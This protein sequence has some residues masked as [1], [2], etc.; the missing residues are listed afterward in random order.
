MTTTNNARDNGSSPEDAR[1]FR[2]ANLWLAEAQEQ[3]LAAVAAWMQGFAGGMLPERLRSTAVR[4]LVDRGWELHQVDH[5]VL[6]GVRA[7]AEERGL[8]LP[9][10]LARLLRAAL[11]GEEA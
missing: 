2:R 3:A 8:A 10:A 5:Q 9:E 1:S 4:Y 11:R 7:W 6:T